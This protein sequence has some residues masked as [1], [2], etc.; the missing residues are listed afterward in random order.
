MG[1]DK[2]GEEELRMGRRKRQYYKAIP[3]TPNTPMP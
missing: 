3:A 1:E 2:N